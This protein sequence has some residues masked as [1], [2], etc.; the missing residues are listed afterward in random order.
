MFLDQKMRNRDLPVTKSLP[1]YMYTYVL[2]KLYL[3]CMYLY[4]VPTNLVVPTYLQYLQYITRPGGGVQDQ[5]TVHFLVR[6]A[7]FINFLFFFLSFCCCKGNSKTTYST[8]LPY[9]AFFHGCLLLVFL[10]GKVGRYCC[11]L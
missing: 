4:T 11:R 7:S 5:C 1:S 8:Y 6:H 9:L 3:Y 2:V 10:L